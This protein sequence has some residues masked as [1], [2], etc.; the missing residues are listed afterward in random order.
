[1][2]LRVINE[3]LSRSQLLAVNE[4]VNSMIIKEPMVFYAVKK[5]PVNVLVVVG[6]EPLNSLLN[7]DTIPKD[8]NIIRSPKYYHQLES[9]R[10]LAFSKGTTNVTLLLPTD[11]DIKSTVEAYSLAILRMC[12]EYNINAFVDGN[13]LKFEYKGH[14]RKFCGMLP[15]QNINGI[16]IDIIISFD[17]DTDFMEQSYNFTH[18][19]FAD[20]ED[21]NRIKTYVGGLKDINPNINPAK[22]MQY[23]NKEFANI[24]GYEY[25][26]DKFT[27]EEKLIIDKL[28]D[29]FSQESWIMDGV[30]PYK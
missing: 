8:T 25:I 23:I 12:K 24:C 18:E 16:C 11:T 27:E 28:Y 22:A 4:F 30:Y 7:M 15:Y 10:V 19:K 17:I 26:K 21:P 1:M 29:S 13:D 9:S 5:D 14:K 3:T 2:R 6:A 20:K